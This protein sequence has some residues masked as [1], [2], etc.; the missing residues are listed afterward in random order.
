ME[1]KSKI[2][3]RYGLCLNDNCQKC[4]D[5]EVQEISIRKELVCAECGKPLRECPPPPPP[6]KKWL[7]IGGAA[8][9]VLAAV[10]GGVAL[11]G[12]S[13]DNSEDDTATAD[14]IA[15]K[16]TKAELELPV[17]EERQLR[18]S[19]SDIANA[20][21]LTWSTTGDAISVTDEGMVKAESEGEAYVV[22]SATATDGTTVYQSDSCLVTVVA[23]DSIPQPSTPGGK[24][25]GPDT[26]PTDTGGNTPPP[27]KPKSKSVFNGCATY[28]SDM[29]TIYIKKTMTLDLH[30]A[31]DETLTLHSGD[32]I[33]NAKVQNGYLIQ[34][35]VV[36][37]GEKRLVTGLRNKL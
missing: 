3:F 11:F 28:D 32:Q 13:S 35:V 24:V 8:V 26:P 17:G 23:T 14:T 33:T 1:Q 31:D 34:G 20:A 5:K 15:I 4:K 37:N 22:V 21:T 9:V 27:S 10:G 2:R 30:T 25:K 29:Q 36:S 6:K 16:L 7:I 19:Q 12:G 18:I